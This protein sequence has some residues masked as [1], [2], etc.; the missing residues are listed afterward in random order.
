MFNKKLKKE[1][2]R[3]KEELIKSNLIVEEFKEVFKIISKNNKKINVFKNSQM[4]Y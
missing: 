2:K 1:L 4:K 3:V